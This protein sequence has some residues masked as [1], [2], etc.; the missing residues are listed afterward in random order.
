MPSSDYADN[1]TD[2]RIKAP[3]SERFLNYSLFHNY[4]P[5]GMRSLAYDY[6]KYAERTKWPVKNPCGTIQFEDEP[7]TPR[8]QFWSPLTAR[9]ECSYTQNI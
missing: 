2:D 1:E 8:F 7:R 6:A 5:Y 9:Y 4:S 3:P